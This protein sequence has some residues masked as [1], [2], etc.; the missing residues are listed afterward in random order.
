MAYWEFLLQKEG[1]LDWLPLETAHVEISEGRYRI[2]AHTSYGDTAVEISLSHLLADQTPPRRK[3]LKR[4]GQ[5]NETGLMVVIPFTHLTPGHWMV[6]CTGADTTTESSSAW[7]YGVQLQVLAIESGVEYWDTDLDEAAIAADLTTTEPLGMSSDFNPTDAHPAEAPA[8]PAPLPTESTTHDRS[9]AGDLPPMDDRFN[10]TQPLEDLPLRLQLQHQALVANTRSAIT[11]PGQVVSF[12]A[13]EGLPGEGTLWLQLRNPETGD[14]VHQVGYALSIAQL[15]GRFD[16]PITL[17]E[18]LDTRLLVGELSLWT[19]T[20]SAQ[21][22]AV[23][24]FT[25]TLNLDALLEVV[26][27]QAERSPETPFEDLT[28]STSTADDSVSTTPTDDEAEATTAKLLATLAPREIPFRLVYLP[29]TGLTLPPVIYRP[30]DKKTVGAPS[31]PPFGKPVV[32]DRPPA[33]VSPSATPAKP[34]DLPPIGNRR[35]PSDP[36]IPEELSPHSAVELPTVGRSL[37]APSPTDEAPDTV[38]QPSQEQT[39][40][41]RGEMTFQPDFQGRFWHRLSALAEA[42]QKAAAEQKAQ[43]TSTGVTTDTDTAIPNREEALPDQAEDPGSQNYEVV[44]YEADD[45]E[46]AIDDSINTATEP[47]VEVLQPDDLDEDDLGNIPTPVLELP[48][49]E[50]VA[51]KPLPILVRLPLYPRRLAVKVWVTDIQSRTLVDRPRWLMKWTP[52]E[53]EQTA[54]L[55]LQVPLGSMEA[56]FEAITIDLATQRESY[57]TSHVRTIVPAAQ[58]GHEIDPVL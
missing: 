14:I 45:L 58:T 18:V 30:I 17:P 3:I 6:T 11:L 31:L 23:Q 28:D 24:G 49:G 52:G 41:E 2:I 9:S 53:G 38:T 8:S 51:G 43:L 1:D 32:R 39:E 5:T 16:L 34:L 29:S 15:P 21:I 10:A 46:A 25:V 47:L 13:V 44:V 22:L 12:S 54:L 4:R 35:P 27:N 7:R 42:A 57:K 20:E 37:S 50:L 33:D 56:Q 36:T 55:Q 48:R 19:A 40:P 26:A